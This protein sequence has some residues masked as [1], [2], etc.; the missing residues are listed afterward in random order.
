[1]LEDRYGNALST[2]SAAARDHYVAGVDAFLA[3]NEGTEE[4]LSAAIEADEGF[5]PAYVARGRYRQILANV[6]GA[7]EDAATARECSAGLSA[8]EQSHVNA[9]ALLLEGKVPAGFAAIGEHLQD[10]PRDAMVVQPCAGVF[11]LIGFNG[12][13]G[14]EADQLA[15]LTPFAGYYSD[16]WWFLSQFAFAQ[17]EAGQ[18]KEADATIERALAGHPRAAHSAHVRAHVHYEAGDHADG[19]AYIGEWRKAFDKQAMM[20]CHVSWHEALW[21][22]ETGDSARAWRIFEADVMPGGAWGPPLNV[23][24]DS[25]SFLFRAE[26]AGEPR[27]A[28]LWEKLGELAAGLFGRPGL[29]FAD[30]H[31]ALTHAVRGDAEH[32]APLLDSPKGLAGD[33]VAPA[34][35]AFKA[36]VAGDWAG[37]I[38]HLVPIMSTHERFGGSRA[39]R[40]LL[41]FTLLSALLQSGQEDEARRLLALRRPMNVGARTVAGL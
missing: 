22:L 39:Q 28:D 10:Y 32:L 18:I 15:Y 37:C 36:Y 29:S 27:R 13:A 35:E 8:R 17:S 9:L 5:A 7:R 20:H 33:L 21:S 41:E 31:V 2:T 25:A 14:R 34:A 23:L 1:M 3:G 24:T 30:L 12:K 16:D 38:A 26:L 6:A 4:A 40:D 19:L 11:G